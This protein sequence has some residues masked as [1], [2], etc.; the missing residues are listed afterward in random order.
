MDHGP[1]KPR[2]IFK[3]KIYNSH[4]HTIVFLLCVAM[5]HEKFLTGRTAI[6]Q[7][8]SDHKRLHQRGLKHYWELLL[9]GFREEIPSYRA[10]FFK[11]SRIPLNELRKSKLSI[12]CNNCRK[13]NLIS[14]GAM[15]CKFILV[16]LGFVKNT[17]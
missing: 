12:K 15:Y 1:R 7:K 13:L 14:V 17:A 3:I 8:F 10:I 16:K 9:N 2:D 5:C 6:A 11:Y 4:L